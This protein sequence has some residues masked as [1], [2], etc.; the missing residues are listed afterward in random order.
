MKRLGLIGGMSPQSAALYYKN[1]NYRVNSLMG[2]HHTA[3][4]ILYS[5][6]F[7]DVVAAM[8][9][10]DWQYLANLL[11]SAAKNLEMIGVDTIAICCNSAHKV[12]AELHDAIQTPIMHILEPTAQSIAQQQIQKIGL[13]GNLI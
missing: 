3:E 13:L 4:L 8:H 9:Q 1:I 6:D 5:V 12:Y 2:E 11:I 7:N 10:H